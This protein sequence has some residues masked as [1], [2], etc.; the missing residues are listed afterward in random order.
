M[1]IKWFWVLAL[2][3]TFDL[4]WCG[5]PQLPKIMLL[6]IWV[7]ANFIVMVLQTKTLFALPNLKN[8]ITIAYC[9]WIAWLII[10]WLLATCSYQ[11]IVSES[12][13]VPNTTF[14]HLLASQRCCYWILLVLLYFQTST[15]TK[16]D[17]SQLIFGSLVVGS[18]ASGYGIYQSLNPIYINTYPA[19]VATFGNINIAGY[20]MA[21]L[22]LL[23]TF[24][25]QN[26][27]S[28]WL[29]L[30]RWVMALFIMIYL[31]RTGS[32]TAWLALIIGYVVYIIFSLKNK[33]FFISYKVILGIAIL[34]LIPLLIPDWRANF[35]RRWQELTEIKTGS[36]AVRQAIWS[37]TLQMIQEHPFGVGPG[38]FVHHFYRYREQYEYCISQ[39]RLVEHP[40]QSWLLQIAELGWIGG[41]LFFGLIILFIYELWKFSSDADIVIAK[42]A[43]TWASVLAGLLVISL[44]NE[45]WLVIETG[46]WFTIIGGWLLYQKKINFLPSPNAKMDHLL[47]VLSYLQKYR[48]FVSII[49]SILL[50]ICSLCPFV[51]D[52][53]YQ[54]GQLALKQATSDI[55]K[56]IAFEKK[57][58]DIDKN[59]V[60]EKDVIEIQRLKIKNA[61]YRSYLRAWNNFS[62]ATRWYPQGI[63]YTEWGRTAL[64]MKNYERANILFQQA[65]QI[66]P[67]L[68][69]A[70]IDLGLALYGLGKPKA[71]QKVWQ[72]AQYFFP[73]NLILQNNIRELEKK[74]SNIQTE[75]KR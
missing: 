6:T 25:Q 50:I 15:F 29:S 65:L 7:V 23:F 42:S 68:E 64:G 62:Q 74:I 75:N 61:I 57:L 44:V 26:I 3:P 71:T 13:F 35:S 31:I 33:Q 9:L 16:T 36:V 10:S 49:L 46:F 37:S 58:S 72:Q 11:F 24:P 73:N 1:K 21:I 54:S 53:Y 63:H 18:I 32:R 30:L 41:I 19:Y 56:L 48:I 4:P 66:A 40:H 69:S 12:E 14:D 28:R 43:H 52:I 67:E 27:H 70:H 20:C 17:Y 5:N 51:A 38:Q 45:S 60:L 59:S 55:D 2:L 34:L 8:K 39:G 22:L 47:Q